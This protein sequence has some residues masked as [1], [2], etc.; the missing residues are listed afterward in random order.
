MT[1]LP[2]KLAAISLGLFLTAGRPLA[3]QAAACSAALFAPPRLFTMSGSPQE[4]DVGDLNHD[5][6]LDV[7]TADTLG[8]ATIFLGNGDGT[9]GPENPQFLAEE[10]EDVRIV[11]VN[12]DG[13]KDIVVSNPL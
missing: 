1:L 7:V 8:T 12:K 13:N 4:I 2:R 10:S 5:G 6:K 9:L 11:D 3:A